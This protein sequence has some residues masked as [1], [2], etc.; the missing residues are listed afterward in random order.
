MLPFSRALRDRLVCHMKNNTTTPWV[1]DPASL[2]FTAPPPPPRH[3]HAHGPKP[4]EIIIEGL[5]AI[6]A[7]IAELKAAVD[8]ERGSDQTGVGE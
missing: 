6:S 2:P 8:E 7:Q 4:H 3:H 5:E 1:A